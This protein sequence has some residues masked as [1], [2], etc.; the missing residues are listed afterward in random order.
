MTHPISL[1]LAPFRRVTSHTGLGSFCP[2]FIRSATSQDLSVRVPT[3][4]L[5]EP[6]PLVDVVSP[7]AA[8]VHWPLNGVGHFWVMSRPFA[9]SFHFVIMTQD[10]LCTSTGLPTW[11]WPWNHCRI[12]NFCKASGVGAGSRTSDLVCKR[13]RYK[14]LGTLKVKNTGKPENFPHNCA[15]LFIRKKEFFKKPGNKEVNFISILF[16]IKSIEPFCRMDLFFLHF[17][18]TLTAIPLHFPTV[19]LKKVLRALGIR[20]DC[21]AVETH[22]MLKRLL[23]SIDGGRG[24][25]KNSFLKMRSFDNRLS[26]C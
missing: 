26:S 9:D 8:F 1:G 13:L 14:A 11:A 10:D 6:T 3:E 20:C 4:P 12:C 5:V 18:T 24:L 21:S 25:G 19:R 22:A 16:H 17:S 2:S 15:H 7:L 23:C